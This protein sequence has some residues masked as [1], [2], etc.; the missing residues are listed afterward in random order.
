[1]PTP[2]EAQAAVK[3][4]RAEVA[5]EHEAAYRVIYEAVQVCL[6]AGMNR[7]EAAAFLGVPWWRIDRHGRYF[8]SLK[9]TRSLFQ[10]AF[11]TVSPTEHD[12]TDAV[13][14]RAWRL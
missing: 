4:V 2:E 11:Q 7:R 12:A 5:R 8:R 9:A 14:R 10:S 1:M 6:A 3:R 13:V